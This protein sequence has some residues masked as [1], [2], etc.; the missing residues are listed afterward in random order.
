MFRT[1]LAGDGREK[2][3]LCHIGLKTPL[4]PDDSTTPPPPFIPPRAT[5]MA[6]TGVVP[7]TTN[8]PTFTPQSPV[9]LPPI[10]TS[11]K[12]CSSLTPPGSAHI[13]HLWS[14]H[15][16]KPPSTPP[17]NPFFRDVYRWAPSFLGVTSNI[18]IWSY[19][20]LLGC[21]RRLWTK[22]LKM[23]RIE[24]SFSFLI[25]KRSLNQIM[26]VSYLSY[27]VILLYE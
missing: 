6:V 20:L 1:D 18:S 5:S 15:P 21:C 27:A 17:T 8:P 25:G 11:L 14:S 23:K 10:P 7:T 16:P 2:E 9:P 3:F 22:L 12:L 19:L 4:L 24:C 13:T 26:E